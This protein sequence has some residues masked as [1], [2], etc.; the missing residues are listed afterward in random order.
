VKQRI[1]RIAIK[2]FRIAVVAYVGLALV[3]ALFQTQLIFP[4]SS[5]QGR[6]DAVVDAPRLNAELV[7]LTTPTG[8]RVVAL[9]GRADNDDSST[10]PTLLYFYGNGMCMADCE[11]EFFRFRRRGFNVMVAEYVGYGMSSGKPSEAGVF[12]TADACFEHLQ[13]RSDIDRSKI[14]PVG[15]SL[16]AAAAMH[17]A[18]TRPREQVPCV[19]TISAFTSM[20]AMA[21]KLFPYLPTGMVLR[22]HF[23]NDVAVTKLDGRPIFLAHGTRDG[24][25]PFAMSEQLAASARAAGSPVTKFDVL[26]GDHNDV[27]DVGGAGLLDA[28]TGFVNT[29]VASNA[30][31]SGA[32]R[33]G[34]AF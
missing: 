32:P 30:A 10:R 24:I 33:T 12:A 22:H 14:V 2:L 17:I 34:F 19:V 27:F 18:S 8:D 21:R 13:K 28:I 29:R 4:G 25:I 6:R 3:L 1:K 20:D 23:R 31:K 16:G 9:F 11:G 26:D 5:T 15:W 7:T